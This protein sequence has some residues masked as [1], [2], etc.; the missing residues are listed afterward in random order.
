MKIECVFLK[1]NVKVNIQ[2]CLYIFVVE[3]NMNGFN[4]FDGVD[5]RV[6]LEVVMRQ[7]IYG[8]N[9]VLLERGCLMILE[10]NRIVLL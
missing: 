2:R 10:E 1:Q 3:V 4:S 9:V 8:F 6:V 7:N 5:L